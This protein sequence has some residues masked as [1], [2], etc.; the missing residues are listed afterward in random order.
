M[1]GYGGD[2]QQGCPRSL[3][4][5]IGG[6]PHRCWGSTPEKVENLVWNTLNERRLPMAVGTRDP[7]MGNGEEI[8]VAQN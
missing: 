4:G 6:D 7:Q 2:S 8:T 5:V 1:D 3:L